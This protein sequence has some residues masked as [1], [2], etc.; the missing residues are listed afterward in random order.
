MTL[1]TTPMSPAGLRADPALADALLALNNAHASEL[2]WLTPE[3]LM[4]LLDRAWLAWRIGRA[5][6]LMIALDHAAVYDNPN[7]R[8]FRARYDRFVYVDRIVVASAA[9]GRGL[10]RQLYEELIREATA[11]GH[12]RIV[13]EVNLDPPNPQSDA[14][15]AALGFAPLATAGIHGGAKTVR[16]MARSLR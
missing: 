6:A 10:A 14:F 8:W 4:Q 11:A 16:Y 2:S 13:C 12:D 1:M 3:T 9:R 5:D 7:H 15:H